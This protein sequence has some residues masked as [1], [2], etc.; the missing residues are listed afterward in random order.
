MSNVETALGVDKRDF[1]WKQL[2]ACRGLVAAR[3]GEFDAHKE[4]LFF[5]AYEQDKS[6]ART[7]D[8]ICLSCPVIQICDAYATENEL[9]G[10][11]GGFYRN[12]K[13]RPSLTKNNHKTPEDWHKLERALGRKVLARG[14]NG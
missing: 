2:A 14:G 6:V 1:N 10:Q 4:D 3:S 9:M 8:E 7:T 11:W 13:G 12:A 5:D